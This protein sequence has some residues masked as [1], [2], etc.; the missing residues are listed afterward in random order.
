MARQDEL[1]LKHCEVDRELLSAGPKP[2]RRRRLFAF[3]APSGVAGG[4]RTTT[5]FGFT[6]VHTAILGSANDPQCMKR[7]RDIDDR[8]AY[9]VEDPIRRAT[10]YPIYVPF[11]GP[12]GENV[13][14]RGRTM[15]P[16]WIRN[17][18]HIM[19]SIFSPSA[20]I[21][22]RSMLVQIPNVSSC[23]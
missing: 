10:G 8:S 1:V 22:E 17:V 14:V 23:Q 6:R 7:A 9:R 2:K 21:S 16:K 5:R 3:R 4:R 11:G 15:S 20:P 12:M 18:Q 13:N 19:L